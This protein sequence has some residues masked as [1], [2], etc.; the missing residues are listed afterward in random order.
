MM[1]EKAYIKDYEIEK[2]THRLLL[3]LKNE[4]IKE[5]ILKKS[6]NEYKETINIVSNLTKKINYKIIIPFSKL[7]FYEGE[8][9]YT[10]NIYQNIGCNTY[11]ERTSENA[12]KYL[13]KKLD[14]YEKK[15]KIIS[16]D[17]NKLTKEIQLALEL[18]ETSNVNKNNNNQD[19]DNY[20]SKN[21]F[22]R[23]DGYLEI[24]EE[25]HS[26]DDENEN[27]NVTNDKLNSICNNNNN[28][29]NNDNNENQQ[30]IIKREDLFTNINRNDNNKNEERIQHDDKHKINNSKSLNVNKQGLL[31]IQENYTS[32]S[33]EID[34]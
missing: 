28:N 12:Y 7:A 23:P 22:V 21:V 9:K 29:N 2:A 8:I 16:D 5:D 18:E 30:K 25:Y 13:E 32:S 20:N 17:I 34:D 3:K 15:Y 10:N 6:I 31:N 24:R 11:C 26:S 1:D 4:K 14:D 19:D 27:Q 33:S